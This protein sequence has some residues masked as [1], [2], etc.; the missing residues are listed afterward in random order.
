MGE[1][2]RER[3]VALYDDFFG[4]LWSTITYNTLPRPIPCSHVV[5][6]GVISNLDVVPNKPVN[7]RW[8]IH[9]PTSMNPRR[10]HRWR[11]QDPFFP[12]WKGHAY[13]VWVC[14][15]VCVCVCV[16]VS[17][18]EQQQSSQKL[19]S[20]YI[21]KKSASSAN[22]INAIAQKQKKNTYREQLHSMPQS[23]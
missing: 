5:A 9:I 6:H 22:H 11:K 4:E 17:K 23:R 1:T 20:Q 3:W 7:Y 12:S 10:S 18:R 8:C 16:C 2:E 14:V 19:N 13:V 21:R 15:W